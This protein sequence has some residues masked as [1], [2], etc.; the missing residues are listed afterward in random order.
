MRTVTVAAATIDLQD[1]EHYAGLALNADGMPSHHLVL[2]S[3]ADK[4]M[5]WPAAVD[6]AHGQGGTLPTRAEQ[7]LLYANLKAQFQP[8]WYWSSEEY[9]D[10]GSCAWGQYFYLGYQGFHHKS[11][12]GR[13]RAVRLIQ[14]TA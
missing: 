6:W 10:D 14:L 4:R 13:C 3:A 11:Y 7:A 9:E 8:D 2:L 5:T 1:G 12:V